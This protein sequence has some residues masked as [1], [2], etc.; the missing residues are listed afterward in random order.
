[1]GDVGT[2]APARAKTDATGC[3]FQVN[4]AAFIVNHRPDVERILSCVVHELMHFWSYQS[5]GLQ[6]FN[7]GV[8]GVDWDE[9][10][11]D[12]LG[13]RTYR[14]QF[15]GTLGNYVTPYNRYPVAL[16]TQIAAVPNFRWNQWKNTG[17][18]EHGALPV[19]LQ[20]MIANDPAIIQQTVLAAVP[21]TLFSGLATWFFVGPHAVAGSIG[22]NA[23]DYLSVNGISRLITLSAVFPGYGGGA[24]V[25]HPI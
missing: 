12:I 20:R 24:D 19:K 15:R 8:G 18:A 2:Y 7:R 1:M 10:S 14:E 5:T 11:A 9:A 22:K 23:V 16:E 21:G 6:Q 3:F 25:A 13:F 4:D 17:S